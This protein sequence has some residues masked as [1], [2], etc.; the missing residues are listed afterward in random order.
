VPLD[1]FLEEWTW[2]LKETPP[3]P[4]EERIPICNYP[5]SR[6]QI[7][8]YKTWEE[9]ILKLFP[10]YQLPFDLETQASQEMI[11]LVQTWHLATQNPSERA[12]LALR[13]VQD[14]I[15][16]LGMEE[17]IHGFKP[18]DPRQV[19]IRR[20]GDCKDKT[21]LLHAFLKMMGIASTPVL[22]NS[23]QG[24]SL[25]HYLP[26]PFLFDH[27][28]LRI[29][30]PGQPVWVDPTIPLQG[31]STLESNSMPAYDW[32][33]PVFPE[34]Q[35]LIPV[36]SHPAKE[37]IVIETH[38]RI[39]SVDRAHLRV[40]RTFHGADADNVRRYLDGRGMVP[41]SEESLSALRN[42][43]GRVDLLAP[44]TLVDDRLANRITLIED[45]QAEIRTQDNTRMLKVFSIAIRNYLHSG[46][47]PGRVFSYAFFDSYWVKEH[48]HVESPFNR[49]ES[50][51]EA[52]TLD[53]E[54]LLYTHHMRVNDGIFDFH[55]ELKHLQDHVPA[56]SSR[57]YWEMA[58]EII[59][60]CWFR[61][62]TA[63]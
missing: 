15:R 48:V 29:D 43:Y 58:N 55:V 23:T 52:V 57:K 39:V 30:L 59:E 37:P 22:V 13:F 18:H 11:D 12:L 41:F 7:T 36:I 51:D 34:E 3:L 21:F 26:S 10:L 35:G 46:L 8:Q 60:Y 6:V 45:Y 44:F 61:L 9:V 40:T 62:A 47:S 32:G 20:Y 63:D 24:K 16:Y 38:W 54:S 33:L 25:P 53:H 56:A 5:L 49:W 42:I 27:I 2:E 1:P 4:N 31:G 19:L 14:Q 17:G 28:V 50:L